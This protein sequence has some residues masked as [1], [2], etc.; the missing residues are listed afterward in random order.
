MVQMPFSLQ[1]QI[2]VVT[3]SSQG[4]GKAAVLAL[5]SAGATVAVVNTPDKSNDIEATCAEIIGNGGRA[6]GYEL[7]VTNTLDIQIFFDRVISE[8]GGLHILVN[9]AG[10]RSSVPTLD[11]TEGDWD[12]VLNVNLKGLFFCCQSAIRHMS[13]TG[14]G[15]IINIA[16]Q[17]AVTASPGRAPYIASKGGVVSLTKSLALEWINQGVT[18]NAVGPGPTSTPMTPKGSAANDETLLRRS[19]INRRLSPDEIAGAVVFLASPAAG[20]VNGH[21]LVVDGGWSVG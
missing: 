2:A 10:V 9:N 12:S 19:P 16:S 20:S 4:I 11:I 17:L 1:G 3:G 8:L 14:Y 18:I 5:A 6:R 7:D 21:H 15:R 13:A